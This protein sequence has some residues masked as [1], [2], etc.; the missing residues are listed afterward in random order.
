MSN[1]ER[2]SRVEDLTGRIFG[3]LKVLER[4]QFAPPGR[5]KWLCKCKCGNV[6]SVYR[7]HLT[8]GGTTSC[9]CA[10]KYV[11]LK[12]LKPGTKFGRLEVVCRTEKKSGNSYMYKCR[13]ECGSTCFVSSASLKKGT[14]K[15]CGC[16]ASENGREVYKKM[17]AERDKYMADG[18]DV[19]NIIHGKC[20]SRNKSGCTGVSWDASVQLWKACI[21]FK[22]RK[23]YLGSSHDLKE[24]V[25]YRKE[26]EKVIYGDFLAWYALKHP[27][28]WEKIKKKSEETSEEKEFEKRDKNTKGLPD[29]R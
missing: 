22:G 8:C 26:A 2:K 19:L 4:D 18:T 28:Q 25:S 29:L 15:S 11:N 24:V 23:Y 16:L 13:C 5:S 1:K 9:G 17:R 6:V 10:R 20:N 27:E 7:N 12:E 3:N 14:T 21:W